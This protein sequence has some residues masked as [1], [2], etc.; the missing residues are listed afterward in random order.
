MTYQGAW[1]DCPF[2]GKEILAEETKEGKTMDKVN[3][4]HYFCERCKIKITIEEN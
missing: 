4:A 3:S 1:I 2:C